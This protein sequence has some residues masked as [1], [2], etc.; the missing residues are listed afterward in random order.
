[1]IIGVSGYSGSGKD[2]L[3]NIILNLTAKERYG[4][5]ENTWEIKKW[6]GKLKTIASLL[7]GIPEF[8]FEDQEFKKTYLPE[9]WNYYAISLIDNGKLLV[10]KGRYTTKEE[11]YAYIPML[12]EIYGEFNIEYVVGMRQMTVRQFLQELGTDTLRDNFHPNTWV[13]ALMSD[14]KVIG[15]TLLEG[16]VRKVREEDLIYPN[17]VI[18]DTRFVN[19]AEAIKKAGGIVIRIDRPGFTPINAHPSETSLDD[20]DFD[21]KIANDMDISNLSKIVGDILRKEKLL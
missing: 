20:W 18:T 16:E 10:Q 8:K 3:G 12:K 17:W 9:E 13:N 21:Y 4:Y 11:A 2:T 6:A 7:T 19:E 5:L 1:M 15:D 14:Y